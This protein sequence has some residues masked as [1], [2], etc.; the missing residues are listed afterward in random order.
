MEDRSVSMEGVELAQA[1]DTIT[2]RSAT[3]SGRL[4]D[5]FS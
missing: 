4:A 2:R 1:G 5:E 3:E